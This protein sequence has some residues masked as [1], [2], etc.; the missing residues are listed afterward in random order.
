[1]RAIALGLAL[2]LTACGFGMNESART[3][4]PNH[5]SG[6]GALT[7]V[8]NDTAARKPGLGNLGIDLGMV[9]LGVARHLDVGIGEAFFAGGKVDVKWS[10]FPEWWIVALALRLG[11]GAAGFPDPLVFTYAG[12]IASI[13]VG[14]VVTPYLSGT[15]ADHWI[16]GR[17]LDPPPAGQRNAPRAGYGDGVLQ[18]AIGVRFF[19]GDLFS[20]SL[21]Y[22][23]WVPLQDD[24]GDGFSF[25]RTHVATIGV[26]FACPRRAPR[27]E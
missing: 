21:E 7:F 3:V 23:L 1:M 11:V 6:A 4:A 19:T 10:P 9:R 16:F 14:D 18:L 20:T 25:F 13:D 26:C 27:Q 8:V 22:G 12:T 24:P 15:Y 2:P 17:Y 5:V